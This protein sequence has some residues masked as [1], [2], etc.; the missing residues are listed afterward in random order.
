MLCS[1]KCFLLGSCSKR[2]RS[3]GARICIAPPT[4]GTVADADTDTVQE[5]DFTSKG[6]VELR[7][8]GFRDLCAG[9]GSYNASL[10]RFDSTSLWL[11]VQSV[12]TT[13]RVASIDGLTQPGMYR[14][15]VCA[16]SVNGITA[17]S[18]CATSDGFYYDVS[19]PVKGQLC[20]VS[21]GIQVDCGEQ[22]GLTYV[23]QHGAVLRWRGFHDRESAVRDFTWALGSASMAADIRGWSVATLESEAVLPVVPSSPTVLFATVVCTN[24]AVRT[25]DVPPLHLHPSA[26]PPQPAWYHGVARS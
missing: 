4:P 3:S 7:W 1:G 14:G 8:D 17:A 13:E 11:D 23:S 20:L 24:R 6:S 9:I 18:S 10:Q 25:A 22:N 26:P 5:V 21:N 19:P 2:Q 12:L 15:K 16:T